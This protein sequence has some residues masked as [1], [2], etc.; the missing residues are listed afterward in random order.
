M[1]KLLIALLMLGLIVYVMYESTSYI[2]TWIDEM[3]GGVQ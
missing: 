3:I 2:K 1:L